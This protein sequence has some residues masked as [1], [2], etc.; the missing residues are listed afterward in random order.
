MDS[1]NFLKKYPVMQLK[2]ILSKFNRDKKLG[3]K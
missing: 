3:I 1:N 2:K